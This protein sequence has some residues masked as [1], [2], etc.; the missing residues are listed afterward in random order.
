MIRLQLEVRA[1]SVQ[2]KKIYKRGNRQF[3]GN[4]DKSITYKNILKTLVMA[5]MY[6]KERIDGMVKVNILFRYKLPQSAS[7]E[8]R[9]RVESG[10]A[11]RKATKPDVDNI[12]KQ[13]LDAMNGIV[14]T[15]DSQI[16]EIKASKWYS[17]KDEV[18]ITIEEAR[19]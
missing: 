12:L 10:M 5:E 18:I 13:L 7:K 17:K 4:S 16:V 3:I 15:D 6:Q 9:D 8:D 11:I 1:L 2:D 14:Y 19:K